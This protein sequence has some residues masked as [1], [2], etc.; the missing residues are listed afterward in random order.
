MCDRSD[1]AL[2]LTDF[3]EG[4]EAYVNADTPSCDKVALDAVSE[5]L[6]Q[7]FRNLGCRVLVHERAGGNILECS[8]GRG[9]RQ[10][11]LLGH[12]DTVFPRGTA[13]E[14]PFKRANGKLTGPG[15]LDMKSG[16][17]MI[18]E[19]LRFFSSGIPD[20]WR[21][22]AILNAD[23]EVGSKESEH[24]I[25][26]RAKS[27]VACVC[28]E[29]SKPDYCTVARKGILSFRLNTTGVEAHSGVNYAMG[30]NAIRAI[31]GIVGQ[32]YRLCD[33]EKGISVNIGGISGGSGKGNIVAGS[34]S[35]LGEVRFY[36]KEDYEP[37][38]KFIRNACADTD[39]P[40]VTGKVEF[41]SYR[42]PMAQ[43][44][45][46][47]GLYD[48]ALRAAQRNGL[49]LKPRTH[50]GGSDGAFAA[51]V[52]IPVIDGMGAGGEFS[53]TEEEYV[54]EDSL[55]PRLK[56]CIDL[57]QSLFHEMQKKGEQRHE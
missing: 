47:A 35:V 44:K 38:I 9:P 27:S 25:R 39:D 55:V 18:F 57:I 52:G 26:E 22:C 40:K 33:E 2:S 13:A 20:G 24:L 41:L 5:K 17:L 14:R 30:H 23:E 1:D 12:M 34:A 15:V 29:P 3:L 49:T 51:D 50:G 42:P 48:I 16:V 11:L 32:L 45:Q 36:H 53:H 8:I 46:S 31:C 4:L 54:K 6:A 28:L 21:L 43:T 7:E 56:M 19:I 10:I 37:I